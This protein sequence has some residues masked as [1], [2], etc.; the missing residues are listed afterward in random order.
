MF[1]TVLK[2]TV[3][4]LLII[5][6]LHFMINN[7]LI[8]M[9]LNNIESK[10]ETKKKNIKIESKVTDTDLNNSKMLEVDRARPEREEKKDEQ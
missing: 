10:F 4:F 9:D 2:N 6:I 3:L 1:A 5:F 7:L 8:D